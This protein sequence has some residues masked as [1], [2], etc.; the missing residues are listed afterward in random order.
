MRAEN[1]LQQSYLKKA[2]SKGFLKTLLTTTSL[3]MTSRENHH[4]DNILLVILQFPLTHCIS[5]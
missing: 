4:F 5:Y 3:K 1:K 2:L